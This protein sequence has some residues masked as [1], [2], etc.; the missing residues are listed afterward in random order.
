MT[1][2]DEKKF[3]AEL[4]FANFH[5]RSVTVDFKTVL[6]ALLEIVYLFLCVYKVVS[7]VYKWLMKE[8]LF[9]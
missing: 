2:G 1:S 8:K 3:Q 6:F 4:V 9:Y 7:H 5:I